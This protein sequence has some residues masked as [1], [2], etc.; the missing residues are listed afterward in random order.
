VPEQQRNKPQE[1]DIE[2]ATQRAVFKAFIS[3]TLPVEG[4]L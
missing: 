3:H 1:R 2:A 4:S